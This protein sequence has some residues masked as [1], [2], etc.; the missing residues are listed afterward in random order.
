MAGVCA[1][2]ALVVDVTGAS[3]RF[4]WVGPTVGVDGSRGRRRRVIVERSHVGVLLELRF[5]VR[6]VG[7]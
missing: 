5:E 1:E 7:G 2:S 6:H 3:I 4:V